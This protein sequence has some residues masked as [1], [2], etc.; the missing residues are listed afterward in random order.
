[1]NEATAE[2]EGGRDDEDRDDVRD[3]NSSVSPDSFGDWQANRNA[4]LPEVD[5]QEI[6]GRIKE[7]WH[8]VGEAFPLDTVLDIAAD[9]ARLD[10]VVKKA[11]AHLP[12]GKRRK[13]EHVLKAHFGKSA[14]Y[15]ARLK[16]FGV[17]KVITR[18]GEKVATGPTVLRA[19]VKALE[20]RGETRPTS[21]LALDEVQRNYNREI[22][23]GYNLALE[24][25]AEAARA[26]KE[27]RDAEHGV[28]ER[29]ED[30]LREQIRRLLQVIDF[31][32]NRMRA[33]DVDPTEVLRQ[34]KDIEDE[35]LAA[36]M[37]DPSNPLSD[38]KVERSGDDDHVRTRADY[39]KEVADRLMIMRAGLPPLA[40]EA[41]AERWLVFAGQVAHAAQQ[42]AASGDRLP[43]I[44]TTWL[45]ANLR[46]PTSEAENLVR[47]RTMRDE[48]RQAID[49]AG[50]ADRQID[51]TL[52][53]L[54]E[55]ADWHAQERAAAK[56]CRRSEIANA[57]G[58]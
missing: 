44:L 3:G 40:D 49:A 43:K 39:L 22:N 32:V 6:I 51:W 12:R 28:R 46:V 31:A 17:D 18:G 4:A 45:V 57:M 21:I 13:V 29:I 20:E 58:G 19:A 26:G 16:R 42:F 50:K 24:R 56:A 9:V 5:E 10:A 8:G 1:M 27:H 34:V 37:A 48:V 30:R 35:S 52:G 25:Q 23:P 41:S 55:L 14:S 11:D 54:L 53:G 47:L 33:A 38:L 7:R 36:D 2:Q 15:I